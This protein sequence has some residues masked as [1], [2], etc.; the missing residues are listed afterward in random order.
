MAYG[1]TPDG[2]VRMRLPEIRQEIVT[3]L[4][5]RL[6]ARGY[7]GPVETRPDSLIGL[8]V[9]SFSERESALWELAE[10]VYYAMYPPSASQVSLDNAVSF[11]G[12]K[13]LAA[14]P[15]RCYVVL[16]GVEGTE[17]EPDS[18]I[19]HRT[20]QTL[21]GIPDGATITAATAADATVEV[22]TVAP[23]T[24]YTVLIDGVL[25]THHTGAAPNPESIINGLAAAL[26]PSQKNVETLATGVRLFTDGRAAF[27]VAVSANLRLASIGT[28]ALAQTFD[29]VSEVALVGDLCQIVTQTPG[30]TAVNNL[31]PGSVGRPDE[32]D[33][34]LRGR[35][36][37]GI[38]RLGAATLP[39]ISANI[40]EMVPGV[41]A[42]KDFENDGDDPDEYGRPPHSVHVVVDGGLDQDIAD[43]IF[44]L[45]GGGIDTV[46]D[47]VLM[48]QDDDGD[49][50]EILFDRPHKVYVWAKA[51]VM[52]LPPEEKVFPTDGFDRIQAGIA[53]EGKTL[54]IGE[55]IVLQKLYKGVYTTPGVAMVDLRLACSTD[56]AYVPTEEDYVAGNFAVKPFERA[57]FDVS[58]VE[59]L[60]WT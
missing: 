53:A 37:R 5:A 14:E 60:P 51:S 18:Q 28:P 6:R 30:W 9:D 46:G 31:Q 8:L 59:V 1:V 22:R 33:A 27:A 15:S 44:R 34:S 49:L 57:D 13:R 23:D 35:Y 58:R 55:D 10:G 25:Y 7:A 3:D 43:A 19:R 4:E 42:V 32:N 12:A 54:D 39:S 50:H 17:I 29:N 52:Q 21:W 26:L 36:K 41:L 38:Y 45:K 20:T 47:T 56:P 48:V 2:F 16:Y 24:D 40:W 11:S